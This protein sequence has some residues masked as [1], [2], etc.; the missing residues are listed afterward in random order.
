VSPST[1]TVLRLLLTGFFPV[2][3]VSARL[4]SLETRPNAGQETLPFLGNLPPFEKTGRE[5]KTSAT[6]S[7]SAPGATAN[8]VRRTQRIDE[9]FGT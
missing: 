7:C 4:H 1:S 6:S 8:D 5:R 9:N 3:L 2:S